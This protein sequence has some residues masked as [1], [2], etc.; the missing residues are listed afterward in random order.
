[1]QFYYHPHSIAAIFVGEDANVQSPSPLVPHTF[2]GLLTTIASISHHC[3]LSPY[4]RQNITTAS[5]QAAALI[6]VVG[7]IRR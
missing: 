3:T 2:F 4:G 7:I 6:C 5:L 1:M